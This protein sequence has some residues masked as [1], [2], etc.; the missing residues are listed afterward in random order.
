M[1]RHN[2]IQI[3]VVGTGLFAAQYDIWGYFADK[4]GV[5][6]QIDLL[7]DLYG[8]I[9]IAKGRRIN[10]TVGAAHQTGKI[11]KFICLSGRGD[12]DVAA[13]ARLKGVDIYE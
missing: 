12:K 5:V 1:F 2:V 13:I 7:R 10:Y 8:Q 4:Q 3:V 11:R 9:H 6:T